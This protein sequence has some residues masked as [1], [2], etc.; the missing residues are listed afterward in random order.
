M[1]RRALAA[2]VLSVA[3]AAPAHAAAV[4]CDGPASVDNGLPQ[5]LTGCDDASARQIAQAL[6][7]DPS[8]LDRLGA[9]AQTPSGTV[10]RL[11]QSI[12]GVPVYDGQIALSFD[13]ASNLDMVQSSAIPDARLETTPGVTAP[14]ALATAGLG[15]DASSQLVIYPNDGRPVLAWHLERASLAPSSDLN[16]IV[17]AQTGTL[18]RRWNAVQDVDFAGASVFEPNPVQTS[19]DTAQR[20]NTPPLPET[21][22]LDNNTAPDAERHT[23]TL[24][25]LTSASALDGDFTTVQA[26]A[27]VA[28][29]SYSRVDSSPL[30]ANFEAVNAYD[31]ITEAQQKIQDLGF[32]NF[33]DDPATAGPDP[34]PLLVNGDVQDNSNYNPALRTITYGFGGVDDAEDSE[35]V[36]HEY[37]HAIQDA[38]VPGFG[39]GDEQGAMGE[40]FGDFFAGMY[41]L[42]QGNAGYESSNRRYCIAEWDATTYNPVDPSNPGSGCLR[43]IDGTN[44]NDGSD[45]GKY[46]NTPSEVHDDGR[47]WSAGMTCIFKG[48]GGDLAARNKA[49]KLVLDSQSKLTP[50]DDNTAFEAHIDAMISSDQTLFAGNDVPLIRNCAAERGLATLG[51]TD[52]ARDRTPPDVTATVDPATPDGADGF[53][54]GDVKVTWTVTDKESAATTNGCGPTTI[55]QNTGDSGITLT[56]TATSAGGMTSKS[57]TIKRRAKGSGGDGGNDDKPPRTTIGKHPRKTTHRR[58]ARFQFHANEDGSTF[59]CSLDGAKF[60]KCHSPLKVRVKSGEH[61]LEVRATDAAGNVEKDPASFTWTVKPRKHRR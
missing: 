21:P 16:A 53:Y 37:G 9:V 11:A 20:N 31:A 13:R 7:T 36:L 28:P 61:T 27:G 57:V 41:Y 50:I 25:H 24:H 59:E 2:L 30:Q 12:D 6:G 17:D 58:R 45:I 47:F 51:E 4:T 42:D 5:V 43:W 39:S 60:S 3:F 1:V 23:V 40:G 19:G 18:I 54:S 15:D 10:V 33:F 49:L 14:D 52:P 46:S 48:L 55:D 22:D 8:D 44:E 26:P 34:L 38:Q 56:C 32:P 29:G 35:V